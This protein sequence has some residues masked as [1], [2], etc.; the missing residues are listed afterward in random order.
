MLRFTRLQVY[1]CTNI[2]AKYRLATFTLFQRNMSSNGASEGNICRLAEAFVKEALANND[3]SHDYWHIH[4]VRNMALRLAR[5]EKLPERSM[6]IVELA[7]LLH[8]VGDWKYAPKDGE[9]KADA[10]VFLRD[11]GYP[12]ADEV[13]DI[14]AKMGF[15]EE[16][17]STGTS[18]YP[19]LAV[20]QDA[21][22]L[23]AIGAVGVARCLTFGGFFNRTLHDP[24]VPPRENLTK[25]AYMSSTVKQTTLNHFYEKLLKLKGMMKTESGRKVAEGRHETMVAWLESF[26]AEWDGRQ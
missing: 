19:E 18:F 25:E 17:S 21:D 1:K 15:K 20:V 12:R 7:A 3:A 2:V 26:L 9:K 6:E 22:R 10:A 11:N 14:I 13:M 24:D 23:D 8:D 16:L 5:D 4:R